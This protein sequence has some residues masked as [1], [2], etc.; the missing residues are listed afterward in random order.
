MIYFPTSSSLVLSLSLSLSLTHTHTY[1]QEHARTHKCTPKSA[2]SHS[3]SHTF[4]LSFSL[5]LSIFHGHLPASND[6]VGTTQTRAQSYD[7]KNSCFLKNDVACARGEKNETGGKHFS[8]FNCQPDFGLL[9]LR[10]SMEKKHYDER[11]LKH[12]DKK[13]RKQQQRESS[14]CTDW[15]FPLKVAPLAALVSNYVLQNIFSMDVFLIL[16]ST[17]H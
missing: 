8:S 7:S 13:Q 12:L 16:M 6:V 4:F 14:S 1:A 17:Y 10:H 5:S 15:T 3:H 2:H 9:T 11:N